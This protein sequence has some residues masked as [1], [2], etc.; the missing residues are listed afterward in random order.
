MPHQWV[1]DQL[2]KQHKEIDELYNQLVSLSKL[3]VY[4]IVDRTNGQ[5][6]NKFHLIKIRDGVYK[7]YFLD[8]E[9]PTKMEWD[10]SWHPDAI[11]E[12][13]SNGWWIP[14]E[15]ISYKDYLLHWRIPS[16]NV[17]LSQDY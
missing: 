11:A 7:R 15:P 13:L 12:F 9:S 2:Q 10:L 17:S 1:T 8:L 14:I 6:R 5:P 16:P 4:M 3:P